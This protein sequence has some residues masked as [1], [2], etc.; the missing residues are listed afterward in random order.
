MFP[1]GAVKYNM[2][3][4]IWLPFLCGTVEM[5][6]VTVNMELDRSDAE[7]PTTEFPELLDLFHCGVL[8]DHQHGF[9]QRRGGGLHSLSGDFYVGCLDSGEGSGDVFVDDGFIEVR[10]LRYDV[11]ELL[12]PQVMCFA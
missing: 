5:A 6:F 2:C 1:T 11:R 3:V 9:L 7:F 10:H 12:F 4:K 8:S